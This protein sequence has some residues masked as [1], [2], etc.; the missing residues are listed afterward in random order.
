MARHPLKS[1]GSFNANNPDT[2]PSFVA[3]VKLWGQSRFGDA[4]TAFLRIAH[5]AEATGDRNTEV[6]ALLYVGGCQVSLFSYRDALK[7]YLKARYVAAE[8]GN[9][10]L[11]G[12]I[13][14]NLSSVYS[15]LDNIPAADQEA[16]RAVTLLESGGE[17]RGLS[18]ALMQL[19]S[20]RMAEGNSSAATASYER[21]IAIAQKNFDR[22]LEAFGWDHLGEAWL[23]DKNLQLAEHA[24]T[25]AY[26]LRLFIH[27]PQLS[28]TRAKLAE[29]EFLKGNPKLAL[30]RLDEVL[31]DSPTALATI[32]RYQIVYRRAQMLSALGRQ[33]E[34]LLAFRKAVE[35][36]NTWRE[37]ALP[38]EATQQSSTALLQSVYA[39][40]ADMAAQLSVRRHDA[41]LAR[42]A[43]EMLATNRAADARERRA[44]ASLE[45]NRLPRRYYAIL[46]ELRRAQASAI[47]TNSEPDEA[48][49]SRIRTELSTLETELG[50]QNEIYSSSPENFQSQKSLT[51]IQQILREEDVLLSFSSGERRS[52]LWAVTQ[53]RVLLLE[54]APAKAVEQ[55]AERWT[56][57]VRAGDNGTTDGAQLSRALFGRLPKSMARK[58]NWLLVSGGKALLGVPLPALPDPGSPMTKAHPLI[59]GHSIRHLLSEY[60]LLSPVTEPKRSA[61]LGIGDP[62]YNLADPRRR[63]GSIFRRATA[64]GQRASA[65]GRLVGSGREIRGAASTFARHQLLTG[66]EA[67]SEH[68]VDALNAHP[69]VIH[70]AVHVISPENHPDRAGLALSLGDN[71]MPELLTA[72]SIARY[73]IPGSLVV[74]SGCDSEQSKPIPGVGWTGL[75]R[76]WLSA[77]A[78]AVIVSAWPTPDDAGDFFHRFYTRLNAEPASESM[79]QRAATALAATQN[80]MQHES[81]YRRSPSFWAAYTVLSKE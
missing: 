10:R 2:D 53:H 35:L 50:I 60:S 7:T 62:I 43:L 75:S 25:E 33:T 48:K 19:G 55:I 71:Q 77:G 6:R 13:R 38:G 65:L 15:Q 30:T 8:L 46:K 47:L 40:A 69:S 18:K 80:Q 51:S 5:A 52:W 58:R 59:A 61:F 12:A 72:E 49:I 14:L 36:A 34:A 44:L 32:P 16:T 37:S 45:S 26:R 64:G 56:N 54:L 4:E 67:D 21:A 17:P 20:L 73:R 63:R 74:L 1:S 39:D 24:L 27:D 23:A 3:A 76:A 41:G 42:E 66:P 22:N 68:I 70:F 29:L 57:R 28:I 81:D 9:K 79:A 11:E 78:S 31:R